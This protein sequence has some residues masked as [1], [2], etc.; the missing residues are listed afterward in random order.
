MELDKSETHWPV[1]TI[2]VGRKCNVSGVGRSGRVDGS[3]GTPCS[4]SIL[5]PRARSLQSG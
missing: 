2:D 4:L 1:A 5:R 3:P